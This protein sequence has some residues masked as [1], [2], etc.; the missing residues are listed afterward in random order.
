MPIYPWL[1]FL[2]VLGVRS[3][4]LAHGASAGVAFNLGREKEVARIRALL[5]L[6]KGAVGTM[7]SSLLLVLVTGIASGFLSDW[8]GQYWI[9]A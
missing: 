2:H 8:W 5:E 6:S 4:L 9:W 1:I 3:F 7:N